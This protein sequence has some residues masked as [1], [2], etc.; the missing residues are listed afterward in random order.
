MAQKK[1]AA[2][3]VPHTRRNVISIAD[4]GAETEAS[5]SATYWKMFVSYWRRTG[6][7]PMMATATRAAIRQYSIAVAPDSSWV[8]FLMLLIMARISFLISP[9]SSPEAENAGDLSAKAY[10]QACALK[11]GW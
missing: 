4:Y 6:R 2:P 5:V 8:K 3:G 7:A 9:L 1:C 10:R 11:R